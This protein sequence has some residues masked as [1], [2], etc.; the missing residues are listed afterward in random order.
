M[1]YD[2]IGFNQEWAA[3]VS[4]A[5]FVAQHKDAFTDTDHPLAKMKAEDRVAYLKKAYKVLVPSSVVVAPP[6]PVASVPAMADKQKGQG[7]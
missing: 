1:I 2:G 3:T 7:K 5:E 4:E 6:A